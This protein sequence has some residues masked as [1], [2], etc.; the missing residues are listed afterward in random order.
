LVHR[1]I[2]GASVEQHLDGL[3]V[4][5]RRAK[6][7]ADDLAFA[8]PDKTLRGDLYAVSAESDNASGQVELAMERREATQTIV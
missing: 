1:P 2:T 3:Y 6:T 4:A 7:T 5:I 8:A